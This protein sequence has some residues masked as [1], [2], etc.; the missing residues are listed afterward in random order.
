MS[1]SKICKSPFSEER[2]KVLF[3][4]CSASH[5]RKHKV[6][7]PKSEIHGMELLAAGAGSDYV[8]SLNTMLL[9]LC[10]GC[11]VIASSARDREV[12]DSPGTAD[13]DDVS[14]VE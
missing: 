11:A 9:W 8:V 3:K 12:C 14:E 1:T 10:R 7:L 5:N 2:S 6:T 4:P 13:A